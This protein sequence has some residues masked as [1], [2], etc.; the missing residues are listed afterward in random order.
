AQFTGYPADCGGL[1]LSG[2]NMAN[3]TCFLAARAAPAGWDVRKQGV[4][5]GPRLVAYASTETHTWIQKAADMTGLGTDGI[6]WIGVDKQQRMDLAALEVQYRRDLE[7]GCRP[8]LVVG[9]AGTVS[10]GAVDPLPELAAFCHERNLWFHVD[11][12]YGAFAAALTGAPVELK[13]L[14][15]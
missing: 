7:E 6:R 15:S 1:L 11:G 13:A 14:K 8:F 10:T 4:A 3:I 12:A 2:G 9:S 5:G